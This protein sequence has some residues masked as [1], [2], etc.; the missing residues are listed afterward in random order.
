MKLC[1]GYIIRAI[2]VCRNCILR[3]RDL[4]IKTVKP[5]RFSR[6]ALLPFTF[7]YFSYKTN[8]FEYAKFCWTCGERLSDT[9]TRCNFCGRL[10]DWGEKV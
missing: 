1:C 7:V 6:K 2:N 9:D 5:F 8:N 4:V 10:I 3:L